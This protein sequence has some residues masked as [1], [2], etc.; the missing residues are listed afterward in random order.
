[1]K[2]VL[3]N[4]LGVLGF[5]IVVAGFVVVFAEPLPEVVFAG[6]MD[7]PIRKV[8]FMNDAGEWTV[9]IGDE[10]TEKFRELKTSRSRYEPVIGAPVG[11]YDDDPLASGTPEGWEYAQY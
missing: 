5:C 2:D 10:A 6:E 1:M 8:S 11:H 4:I 7:G 9:L 3:R